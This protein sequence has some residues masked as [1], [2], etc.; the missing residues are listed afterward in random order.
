MDV[1]M[2]INHAPYRMEEVNNTFVL[3]M[4]C[5]SCESV[6]HYRAGNVSASLQSFGKIV[7][8]SDIAL[9]RK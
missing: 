8:P 7:S 9:Q 3:A 6:T 1:L 4:A 2:P 5:S